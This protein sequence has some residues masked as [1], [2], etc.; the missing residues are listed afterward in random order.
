MASPTRT[1]YPH[2]KASRDLRHVKGN[3]AVIGDIHGCAHTLDTLL[4]RLGGSLNELP[5][6]L[7]LVSVGDIHDKGKHSTRVLRWAMDAVAEGRLI[8][9][10]SNHGAALVRRIRSPKIAK[11]SVEQT[12]R[13]LSSEPDAP[14]LLLKTA[15]FLDTRPSFVRLTGGPTGELLVAH[16]GVAERLI[17]ARNLSPSE[18]RFSTLAREFQWSGSQTVLVGHMR[19]SQPTRI[20]GPGG[21]IIRIDTGCAEVGGSL[22]AYLPHE[23][24]FI[25][26]PGDPRDLTSN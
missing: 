18:R 21:D 4:Q 2:G 3:F 17:D 19:T 1:A 7:T 16:A 14:E 6:D 10:D 5:D 25:S 8:L 9:V 22:T 15:E 23:D 24:S 26:V 13:E 12:F 20:S 11:P